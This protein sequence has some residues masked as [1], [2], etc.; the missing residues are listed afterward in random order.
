VKKR[1]NKKNA[2]FNHENKKNAPDNLKI[3]KMPQIIKK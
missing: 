3:K 2:P 1:E